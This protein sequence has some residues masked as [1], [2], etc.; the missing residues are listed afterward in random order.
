MIGTPV[1]YEGPM[2]GRYPNASWMAEINEALVSRG[3]QH[4]ESCSQRLK[5]TS[6]AYMVGCDGRFRFVSDIYRAAASM[7]PP[8]EVAAEA[9]PQAAPAR[10]PGERIPDIVDSTVPL[11]IKTYSAAH[12]MA[13]AAAR[14]EVPIYA[15]GGAEPFVDPA[16]SAAVP[17]VA[18]RSAVPQLL[19]PGGPV[20]DPLPGIAAATAPAPRANGMPSAIPSARP[21]VLTVET[22]EKI[23]RP[24]L[25]DFGPSA[26]PAAAP[27][28]TEPTAPAKLEAKVKKSA[29][30]ARRG[31]AKPKHAEKAAEAK[32]VAATP[33]A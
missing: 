10:A 16:L 15:R 12:E 22:P 21:K 1:F 28:K 14:H 25:A 32:P 30:P 27:E 9:E 24:R 17:R 11:R 29:G 4:V 19:Q 26:A 13:A 18:N 33:G 2:A 3:F 5:T 20:A 8:I 23:D 6:Y 31:P 7:S